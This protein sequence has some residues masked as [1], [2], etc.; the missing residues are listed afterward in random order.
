ML[1]FKYKSP[2][3]Y[4]K[5]EIISYCNIS[6]DLKVYHI[7]NYLLIGN[8]TNI[9]TFLAERNI[10]RHNQTVLRKYPSILHVQLHQQTQ[11]NHVI[12]PSLCTVARR[13]ETELIDNNDNPTRLLVYTRLSAVGTATATANEKVDSSLILIL[14]VPTMEDTLPTSA[15]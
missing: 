10:L 12:C 14:S 5:E 3:T 7:P 13:T 6:L 4:E 15:R 1:V 8:T 11:I 2:L 9:N